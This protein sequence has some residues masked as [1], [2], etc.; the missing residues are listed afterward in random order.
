[1]DEQHI[2]VEKFH[3]ALV[4]AEQW[5]TVN[6][7]GINAI[8]VYPVPD[9]DTG[10]NMLL[11]WRQ[12]L[13]SIK[14]TDAHTFNELLNKFSHGA[15]LGARGNSGV[16]LSQ[17][18]GGLAS[19]LSKSLD[20]ITVSDLSR[21]LRSASD[22]AYRAITEPV[23]GTMLTVM[24][25]AST[26]AENSTVNLEAFL[27]AV[28]SESY[29][30][31]ARTPE[32]LPRLKEAGVVDSGGMG[33][34]VILE[35]IAVALLER[36]LPS[37]PVVTGE[38]KVEMS[39][40]EHEGY[41]YCTEFVMLADVALKDFEEELVELGGESILVVGDPGA[42]RVHVHLEDPGPAL[43]A[44]VSHGETVS[45][46]IDNMQIQ[47]DNWA[48]QQKSG[49]S[50][51]QGL[52]PS[53][54]LVSVVRGGG[55]INNF[56]ELGANIIIDGGPTG[57][58]SAGEL[59]EAVNGSGLEHVIILP[60]DKDVVLAAEQAAESDPDFIRVIPTRSAV[61]GLSAAMAYLPEGDIDEICALMN[62]S[63]ELVQSIEVSNSVRDTSVNG[64]DI[65]VGAGIGFLD[66]ELVASEP[67][68]A[69]TLLEVLK[70]GDVSQSEIMTLYTGDGA[71]PEEIEK[72]SEM[73]E[74]HFP[75][76]ELDIVEGGQPLYPFIASLE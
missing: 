62:E 76:L 58:A 4:V 70:R 63:I 6:R 44:A 16:I 14:D 27:E 26:A 30:S 2:S 9:G 23:E 59:I 47:H 37:E 69:A 13:E 72:I 1:M 57:K 3:G 65:R 25:E 66:G 43:S 20:S 46:K 74:S 29:D 42:V 75:S 71:T 34:A 61:S 24:R 68:L 49:G 5:L 8:N 73:T 10:T 51:P 48:D 11:T 67:S 7:D 41:G 19:A 21:G 18:I 35:G 50:A 54:G 36:E 33:V 15:L 31:V 28:V 53:I 12:A 38:I 64:I 40:V 32:L 17:M 22:N 60:N 56:R 52:I 39:G 45:I 55:L